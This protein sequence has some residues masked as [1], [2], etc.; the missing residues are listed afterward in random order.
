NERGLEALTQA[1]AIS[2]IV[3]SDS[4]GTDSHLASFSSHAA[5]HILAIAPLLAQVITRIVR[6]AP[7]APLSDYWP[8]PDPL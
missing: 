1:P 4:V 8:P 6:G 5:V 2:H 7:I 3:L